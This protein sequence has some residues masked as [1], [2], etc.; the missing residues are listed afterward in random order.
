MHIYVSNG[1]IGSTGVNLEDLAYQVL[2]SKDGL[3]HDPTRKRFLN[4][5]KTVTSIYS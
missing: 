5:M 3:P 4:Y 1:K 2:K